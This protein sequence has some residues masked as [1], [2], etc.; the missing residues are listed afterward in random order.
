MVVIKENKDDLI[1]EIGINYYSKL[2][3]FAGIIG[4]SIEEENNE[5]KLEFNPDRPDLFSFYALKSN[6]KIFYDGNY[7]IKP[8]FEK[9]D[10]LIRVDNSVK[11]ERPYVMSFVARGKPLGNYYSHIIDYQEKLHETIGK[12]R[13]KMAIGIHDLDNISPPFL[14]TMRDKKTLEFTTYDNF[15]GTAREILE[16]HDKG[17]QYRQLISSDTMVPVILDSKEDVMSMPPIINGLKSKI[18]NNTSKLFFD[19]TGTDYNAVLSAFYLFAYEMSYIGYEVLIPDAD[20]NTINYDWRKVEITH[21]E[22]TKLMG[23]EPDNTVILLRKMGYRCEVTSGGYR[24]DVPGNRIDVM[25]PVDIIEDIAKAY[26]YGRIPAR[27]LKTSGTGVPYT[28]NEDENI[29]KGILTSINYQE[30]RSFILNSEDFYRKTG[31]SGDVIITNPKSLEYSVI[32]DK[33]YPG[34]ISLLAIN[35][36]RKLPLKIFEIGQ[37]VVSGNQES[38]LCV[39]Y[40]NSKAA[41]SDI[42]AVLEYLLARTINAGAKVLQGNYNEIISGRGGDIVYENTTLGII[43]EMD[44]S[45]LVDFGIQNPVAFMEIN[46]DKLRNIIEK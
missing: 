2:S 32:R 34:I 29:I 26:G 25:G 22:I 28:P 4:Y 21:K 20:R 37:V 27:P 44:P 15:H 31:Y 18:G 43:G 42:Y 23:L 5:V 19:I 1:H 12:S 39:L 38:H 8:L 35:K 6:M 46:L 16:K 45:I 41:Y 10:K 33:L 40:N 17:K 7:R 9:S 36:R 24:V 3:D 14:F 30:V 11:S 13:K